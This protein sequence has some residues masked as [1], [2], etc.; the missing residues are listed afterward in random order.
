MELPELNLNL[1]LSTLSDLPRRLNA[2]GYEEGAIATFLDR[3]DISELSG[4]EYP[5]YCSRTRQTD[6]D[7]SVLIAV[8]LMC[9]PNTRQRLK[10]LLGPDI[11]ETFLDCGVLVKDS[12]LYSCTCAIYPCLGK[13]IFTDHWV[14][15]SAQTEGKV[16]ELGTDSYV[17]ARVTPRVKVRR[18]LDLCTGSGVHAI[19][20]AAESE[21]S[22]A[23]DINP[24]ALMYTRL[25]AAANGFDCS[26]HLGDLYTT[27]QGRRFDLITANPPFVPSP[28]KNVLIHRSAGET[29]EEVPE[30]LVAGLPQH[31]E[32][33]GLFS[34]VLDHPVFA[35]ETYLDRLERWLG[36]KQGWGIAVLTFNDTPVAHYVKKHLGGVEDY[37][38]VYKEYLESYERHGIQ[39][40]RFANVF[41]RRLKGSSPNWKVQQKSFWPNISLVPEVQRWLECQATYHDPE[42]VPDE[43]WKPGLSD[44]YTS[45]WRDWD[46][47]RGILELHPDKWLQPTP[48]NGDEVNLV[49]MMRKADTAIRELRNQWKDQGGKEESFM[50][51]LRGLGLRQALI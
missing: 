37:D 35:D 11:F 26:T 25:N 19:L 33:G 21:E 43:D 45:V 17:L 28:D 3:W 8:F 50:T 51:A 20:S 24:R 30:R 4:G 48:L 41:I 23:V 31:L 1:D 7:L 34:M 46:Q 22:D 39:S 49:F 12:G 16:Y 29:G 47:A 10:G 36:E 27:V 13:M 44:S 32:P 9:L 18:A 2:L 42:W 6:S 40:V 5:H 14:S 38:K 15:E